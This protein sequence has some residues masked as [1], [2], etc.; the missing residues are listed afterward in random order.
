MISPISKPYVVLSEKKERKK[1]AIQLRNEIGRDLLEALKT[2]LSTL[3]LFQLVSSHVDVL[4]EFFFEK[5][6]EKA[7]KVTRIPNSMCTYTQ[8]ALAILFAG[9]SGA[10]TIWKYLNKKFPASYAYKLA[11]GKEFPFMTNL[12]FDG[13]ITRSINATP[14]F[15]SLSKDDRTK[16]IEEFNAP[17]INRFFDHLA[18]KAGK[19]PKASKLK[20]VFKHL[21][22]PFNKKI[23]HQLKSDL[24]S[25]ARIITRKLSA[26]YFVRIVDP[27]ENIFSCSSLHAFTIEQFYAN[28][29]VKYRILQSW[30]DVTSLAKDI[31]KK[32]YKEEGAGA[33]DASGMHEFLTVLSEY[34][35]IDSD[36][37]TAEKG[38]GYTCPFYFDLRFEQTVLAGTAIKYWATLVDPSVYQANV[39]D[40][41]SESLPPLSS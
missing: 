10:K 7:A 20:K 23:I 34:A 35:S 19:E 24:K 28:K 21:S 41:L 12:L 11:D 26:I 22:Y 2:P 30:R 16:K 6:G 25:T 29:E 31:T 4:V 14:E 13:M 5:M 33:I 38:F 40:F 18:R 8:L 1:V 39:V 27:D 32:G 37:V 17:F 36:L 3:K 9:K 15:S